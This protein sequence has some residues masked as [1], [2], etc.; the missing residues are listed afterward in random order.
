MLPLRSSRTT[1]SRGRLALCGHPRRSFRRLQQSR[2]GAA[3]GLRVAH[4]SR[5]H[6]CTPTSAPARRRRSA[7]T[8]SR[9]PQRLGNGQRHVRA[10][11]DL[12]V[13]DAVLGS[14]LHDVDDREARIGV[15]ARGGQERGGDVAGEE[16]VAAAA[17]RG[18]DPFRLGEG[19]DGEAAGALEPALVAGACDAFKSAKPLPDVP[20]QRPWPFS[21]RWA[22]ARQTSSAPASTRSSSRKSQA[23][24][25]MLGAPV[26]QAP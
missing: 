23:Q 24:A 9:S 20:W 6:P 19:V 25:R 18:G 22:P 10:L 26:H 2:A 21:F 7:S 3:A 11:T 14:S 8:G 5:L 1:G 13:S 16:R 12:Q 4:T 15:E 17:I